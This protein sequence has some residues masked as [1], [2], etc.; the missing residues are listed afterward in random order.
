MIFAPV[1]SCGA[2]S[3]PGPTIAD[4][5]STAPMKILFISFIRSRTGPIGPG[6]FF[7]ISFSVLASFRH[8]P[9]LLPSEVISSFSPSANAT[10]DRGWRWR[11]AIAGARVYVKDSLT[12]RYW[13]PYIQ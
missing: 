12:P 7:S 3:G 4:G 8:R 9:C 10:C 11:N 6:L 13:L 2:F 1:R 5:A